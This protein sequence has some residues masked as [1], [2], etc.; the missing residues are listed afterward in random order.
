MR[1]HELGRLVGRDL[2]RNKGALATAGFGILAGTAALMF[3]LSLGLGVRSV[4]LGDV[5][6]LDKIELEPR[7]DADPGLLSLVLGGGAT[8]RIDP[9]DVEKLRAM[10]EVEHV[11]PKLRFAFP[12]SARGG[13]ELIGRDVGT[14][15][16]VGD[17][18]DPDLVKGDVHAS[19]AFEDPY[20]QPGPAC[21]SD[22]D[23]TE[24]RYCEMPSGEPRG[25]CVEPV[26]VL[27]SRYLVELFNKGIAP[28]H[29]LPPVGS[30]LLERA[31]GVTFTMRLGESL[32][33]ASKQGKVRTV[34]GRVVG[35]SPRA[36]DL[37]L[38]LP[39]DTVRRWNEEFAGAEAGRAYTS[40]LVE[41]RTTGEAS[42]IID[43]GAKLGLAP[44]DN[45]ARD[46]SVLVNGVTALLSLVAV[47]ILLLA[48]S[49]IAYTFRALLHE[50][51]GEIGLYRAVG[52]A[53]GDILAWQ[54]SLAAVV[55]AVYAS[56]GV[57][58]G[59][60]ST[61]LADWLAATRLPSF[62]FKPES[63]FEV[64][65]WLVAGTIAFGSL[66]AV[67]GAF[68]PARRAAGSDPRDCLTG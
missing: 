63:F 10:P 46:V 32:L 14:S 49:N 6:P 22:A 12:A 1:T 25:K 36:I 42:A 68:G 45:S 51:R 61:L 5:F 31:S 29:G 20:K 67:F 8:P 64:P 58:V 21:T 60:A 50:R 59:W 19:W 16:M 56:L 44:K 39:I 62:P 48:G 43:Q 33:G 11:Y 38:T 13:K 40:V 2:R 34:R 27:V 24:P 55:G 35:V 17:G 47:V 57:L 9:A 54:L 65:W 28:A 3:F 41:A 37:G 18:V 53:K 52:A 66:F 30:V 15:E 23:C 26:P 7:Q 4:L